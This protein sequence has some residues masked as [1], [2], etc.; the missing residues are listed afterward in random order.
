MFSLATRRSIRLLH[1]EAGAAVAV[2]PPRGDIKD[3]NDFLTKI[4]RGCNE[5]S[6]KFESWDALFTSNSEVMR[7]EL[8]IP[9][10]HRKYILG[11]VEKYKQGSDLHAIGTSQKKKW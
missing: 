2:P 10:K 1:T 3:V 8:G 9:T 6:D 7:A 11:W 4:G 5:F